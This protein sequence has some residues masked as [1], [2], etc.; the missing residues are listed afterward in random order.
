MKFSQFCML[1]LSLPC[2]FANLAASAPASLTAALFTCV[3]HA[4]IGAQVES[5]I[6]VP[7]DDTYA[8]A[9]SGSILS[10]TSESHPPASN[11]LIGSISFPQ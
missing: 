6:I 3:K 2:F 8:Y 4:L 10:V 1:G 11:W 5:R 7:S 9:S